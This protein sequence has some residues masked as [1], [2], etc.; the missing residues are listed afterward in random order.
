MYFDTGNICGSSTCRR[1]NH[2]EPAFYWPL[3]PMPK[4]KKPKD[5]EI[6][7][8]EEKQ[9]LFKKY[10]SLEK[11]AKESLV[12]IYAETKDYLHIVVGNTEITV[13]LLQQFKNDGLKLAYSIDNSLILEKIR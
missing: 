11:H 1:C 5:P 13:E 9:H 7:N 4:C 8:I 12:S 6:M 3:S 10:Q 2:K